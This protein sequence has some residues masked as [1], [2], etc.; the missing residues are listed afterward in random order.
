M[1]NDF[2]FGWFPFR[3]SRNTFASTSRPP[4]ISSGAFLASLVFAVAL[5]ASG[6]AHAVCGGSTST[7]VK[8]AATGVHAATRTGVS[9]PSSCPSVSNKTILANVGGKVGPAGA[10]E[11]DTHTH[12]RESTITKTTTN[13]SNS[14][15]NW[16]KP[17]T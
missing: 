2:C 12:H 3:G 15:R 17:K 13:A 5:G 14:H 7:G 1:R 16:Y 8:P 9:S 4:A 6:A 10:I 11:T